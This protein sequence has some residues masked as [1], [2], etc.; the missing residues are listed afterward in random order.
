MCLSI[1]INLSRLYAAPSS[2]HIVKLAIVDKENDYSL[3]FQ[4]LAVKKDCLWDA[5]LVNVCTF[6]NGCCSSEFH[7]RSKSEIRS[8]IFLNQKFEMLSIIYLY[9]KLKS[10]VLYFYIRSLKSEVLNFCIR[11]LKSEVLYFYIRSLKSEVLYFY[12]ISKVWKFEIR[13]TIF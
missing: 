10:E 2:I 11:S 12:G 7:I 6:Y 4:I 8:T 5:F 13:S 1:Q 9:E 3:S